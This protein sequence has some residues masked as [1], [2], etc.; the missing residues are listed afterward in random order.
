[1]KI[2]VP[3]HFNNGLICLYTPSVLWFKFC[4]V[5]AKR[6][7]SSASIVLIR[8]VIFASRQQ[9][10]FE[11]R[12]PIGRQQ[13]VYYLARA[14]FWEVKG[15]IKVHAD[16]SPNGPAPDCELRHIN[17]QEQ[18][19][20]LVLIRLDKRDDF[21]FPIVNVPWLN[22]D[23]PRLQSYGIYISQ[24]VRFARCCT[25]VYEFHSKNL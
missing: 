18:N 8:R 15:Q 3:R 19:S 1:M 7:S 14:V 13:Y 9:K 12:H 20:G 21:G 25:S 2:P 6:F 5:A 16:A 10:L 11:S 23:V 24:L 22:G 4:K 17:K